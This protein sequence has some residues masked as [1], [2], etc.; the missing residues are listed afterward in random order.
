LSSQDVAYRLRVEAKDSRGRWTVIYRANREDSFEL[1]SLLDY[2]RLRGTYNPKVAGP[3][4]QYDGFTRWLALSI[5]ATHHECAAIRV[6]VERLTLA[7]R[8]RPSHTLGV[9]HEREYARALAP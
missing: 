4:A 5:M 6:S 9:A 7:T 3:R 8:E 1:A 2:R